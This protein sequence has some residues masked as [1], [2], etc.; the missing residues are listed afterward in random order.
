[1]NKLTS[2]CAATLVFFALSAGCD[3]DDD[4][5][6]PDAGTDARPADGPGP[7][8]FDMAPSVDMA[9]PDAPAADAGDALADAT[10]DL[11]D[12]AAPDGAGVIPDAGPGEAVF[13]AT[14][15]G[16]Q[17][18]PPVTTA[19]TGTL[20]LVL[21][22]A[23]NQVTYTLQHTVMNATVAHLHLGAAGVNGPPA[24]TIAP[25]ST[26]TMGMAAITA[27]Q[28]TALEAGR[29]YANVHSPANPMGEIRGQVIRPGE[30]L[31]SA[32]LSGA[33]EV[34]AV[35][36]AATGGIGVIVNPERTMLRYAGDVTGLTPAM[37]HIHSGAVGVNGPVVYPLTFTGTALSGMQAITAADLTALDA[38]TYY[39]NVH[40][41]ANPMGEIRGQLQK[42]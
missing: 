2:G 13:V 1:M 12:G 42:R 30:T 8:P 27:E 23:R 38:G 37:A 6:S 11:P 18:V 19:A 36:T 5:I 41:A 15:S 39:V 35:T 17:E 3:D 31:Y 9:S 32:V 10:G 34:P 20:S 29:I 26:M 33:S 4:T 16:A 28:V 7:T 21:N 25:L 22:A 40:T 24:I 14:L